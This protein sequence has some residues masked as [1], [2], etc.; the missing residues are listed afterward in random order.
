VKKLKIIERKL[1]RER[2]WG[3][4]WRKRR[5]IEIDPRLSARQYLRV[6]VHELVH[7]ADPKLPEYKVRKMGGIIANNLWNH[8][9]KNDKSGVKNVDEKVKKYQHR[10]SGNI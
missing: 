7:H 10:P 5:L 2:S 3:L 4:H 1:G 8:L 9:I 6:L